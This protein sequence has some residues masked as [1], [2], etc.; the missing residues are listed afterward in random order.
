[1]TGAAGAKW[2]AGICTLLWFAIVVVVILRYGW[3]AFA[4]AFAMSALANMVNALSK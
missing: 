1:M 4:L 2:A 3:G